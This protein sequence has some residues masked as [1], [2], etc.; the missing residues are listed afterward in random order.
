ME[1]EE[2]REAPP[3][4]Q[5]ER[6][7]ESQRPQESES[8]TGWSPPL[9]A[10]SRRKTQ[11]R[12]PR[13]HE[14]GLH[15]GNRDREP[16]R[17]SFPVQAAYSETKRQGM[18]EPLEDFSGEPLSYQPP[19]SPPHHCRIG[20]PSRYLKAMLPGIY[21]KTRGVTRAKFRVF[22][23][24]S[25]PISFGKKRRRSSNSRI[26]EAAAVGAEGKRWGG[27]TTRLHIGTT[28]AFNEGLQ[29]P[30]ENL[31]GKETGPKITQS[32]TTTRER[33]WLSR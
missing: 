13:C 12:A 29:A 21:A 3:E 31:A 23:F 17:G 33:R 27:V 9:P 28:A 22:S 5:G 16:V 18:E 24:S 14:R 1:E 25:L 7:E 8:R 6:E 19:H 32:N 2:E 15:P 11:R 10:N 4:H 26:R 20:P 30:H